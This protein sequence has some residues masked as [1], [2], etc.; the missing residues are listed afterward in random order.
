MNADPL[1]PQVSEYTRSM[2]GGPEPLN[3]GD[4]DGRTRTRT[5]LVGDSSLF[6]ASQSL[7]RNMVHRSMLFAVNLVVPRPPPI[8][9]NLMALFTMMPWIRSAYRTRAL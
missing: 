1:I 6:D 3:V 9:R 2:E 8:L 4:A 7:N 5:S